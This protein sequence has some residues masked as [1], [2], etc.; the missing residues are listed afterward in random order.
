MR[1]AVWWILLCLAIGGVAL[2]DEP[3]H[4]IAARVANVSLLIDTVPGGDPE[5]F[6][7]KLS[8]IPALLAAGLG[9]DV[10]ELG[11]Y[12]YQPSS[13]LWSDGALK[14]RAIALP[15]STQMTFSADGMWDFPEG[16]VLIKNF[17][18]PLDLR[19]P[20]GTAQRIETRLLVKTEGSWYGYSYRWNDEET[21]A[22][23]LA[24][25]DDRDFIRTDADGDLFAYT[26]HYPS[27]T[28]CRRCHHE[29]SNRVLGVNTAQ[30][31]HD[32]LYP[33]SGVVDNQIRALAHIGLFNAPLPAT[34]AELPS[35]PDLYDETASVA[36]RALSYLHANCAVCHNP[37]GPT[38]VDMDLRWG[39]PMAER[40]VLSVAAQSNPAGLVNPLRIVPGNPDRS[41]LLAR[42]ATRDFHQ[43]PPLGSTLVDEDAVAVVRQW[44]TETVVDTHA[45]DQNDNGIV[46]LSELLRVI[47]LYNV[48]TYHCDATGEDGFAPGSGEQA[49][50]TPHASDYAPQNWIVSLSELLRL[51][52]FYNAGGYTTCPDTEDGFCPANA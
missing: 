38:W 1:L 7:Q 34:P 11:I 15:G 43:M 9:E 32:F 33:D 52:Q 29:S 47:Q 51:I 27:R 37:E 19:D 10:S 25:G 21:D 26:W 30:M 22:T 12:P 4:G 13:Q 48:G 23:L 42:M 35:S 18:L 39:V 40:N 2:A 49:G 44:I 5:T 6:P 24:A 16:A 50:C 41:M 28:E 31:N 3:P 46:S 8:D 14:S 20:E 45:A 36:D 17:A